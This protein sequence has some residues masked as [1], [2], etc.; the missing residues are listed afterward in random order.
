MNVRVEI[1][2][3]R[4]ER[5]S[6]ARDFDIGDNDIYIYILTMVEEDRREER[7]SPARDFGVGQ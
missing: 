7:R 3:K 6:P 1:S 2:G 5:G 4:E